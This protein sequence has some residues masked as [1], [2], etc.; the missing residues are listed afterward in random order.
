MGRD[1]VQ[2]KV[3]E[4]W[5]ADVVEQVS[6]DLKRDLPNEDGILTSNLW[7]MKKWYFYTN[8]HHQKNS[9]VPLENREKVFCN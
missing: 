5:G 7:Y 8:Q 4:H 3:E 6:L 9:N 1:L 2:K